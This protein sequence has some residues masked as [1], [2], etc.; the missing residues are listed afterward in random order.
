YDQN[1][2]Y[3]TTTVDMVQAAG[4]TTAQFG[5]GVEPEGYPP[6]G[7]AN[8]WLSGPGGLTQLACRF[9]TAELWVRDH[10]RQPN[11][12]FCHTGN[13]GGAGG[14]AYLLS[15]YGFDSYYT[16]VEMT[17]GPPFTRIDHGCVCSLNATHNTIC[18]QGVLSECYQTDGNAFIDPA[19]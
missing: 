17:S 5:W 13:S 10:L 1:F 11:T 6:G 15:H 4:F 2:Q 18:G 14:A 12:P 9:G 7:A 16:Y 3:G 19:Y 8:G